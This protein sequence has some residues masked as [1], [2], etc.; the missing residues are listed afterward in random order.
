M[1]DGGFGEVEEDCEIAHAQLPG[2]KDVQD[3]DARWVAE[4]LEEACE[5]FIRLCLEHGGTRISDAVLMDDVAVTSNLVLSGVNFV[6][7]M[8]CLACH[9]SPPFY[10]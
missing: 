9:V 4:V 8:G 3:A 6:L 7:G 5:F 1:G 2:R 10:S